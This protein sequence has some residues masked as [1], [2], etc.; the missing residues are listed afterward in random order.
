VDMEWVEITERALYNHHRNCA[1]PSIPAPH[2]CS[3]LVLKAVL[4]IVVRSGFSSVIVDSI[5]IPDSQGIPC[6]DV[7]ISLPSYRQEDTR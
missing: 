6:P 5:M 7:E 1:S 2:I 4:T 3:L